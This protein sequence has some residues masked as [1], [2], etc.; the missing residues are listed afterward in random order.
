MT[1]TSDRLHLPLLAAGQAQKELTHNEALALLDVL[2]QPVVQSVAPAT[3]PVSPVIG[4]SW[5]IGASPTGAWAGQSGK[6]ATWTSGGWRFVA[7]IEGMRVWSVTDSAFA[8]S[9]TGLWTLGIETALKLKIAGNQ[10]VGARQAAIPTPAG[11]TIVDVEARAA[12]ALIL[13]ALRG[14]GLIQP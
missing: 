8:R 1:E 13:S 11:G 7:P 9:E 12:L 4:Q 2:V 5:I 3:I 10:I 6:L 14:H